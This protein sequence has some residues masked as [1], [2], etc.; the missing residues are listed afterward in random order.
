MRGP[1]FADWAADLVESSR[2]SFGQSAGVLCGGFRFAGHIEGA[3]LGTEF[4]GITQMVQVD[5][6]WYQAQWQEYQY[7]INTIPVMQGTN[8]LGGL[9]IPDFTQFNKWQ[10]ISVGQLLQT[11]ANYPEATLYLPDPLKGTSIPIQGGWWVGGP[12][13]GIPTPPVMTRAN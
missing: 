4:N 5:G 1:S 11:S 6:H 8:D 12:S 7:Q 9:T 10:P 3:D 13:T 2:R